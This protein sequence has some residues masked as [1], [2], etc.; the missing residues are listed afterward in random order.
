MRPRPKTRHR[1]IA[2]TL[3]CCHGGRG[4][5]WRAV[6]WGTIQLRRF[7]HASDSRYTPQLL[8]YRRGA[9]NRRFGPKLGIA[10]FNSIDY[11]A[12]SIVASLF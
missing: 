5:I 6:K 3:A 9:A 12:R 7:E 10:S 8:T 1:S 2:R 11:G 4:F